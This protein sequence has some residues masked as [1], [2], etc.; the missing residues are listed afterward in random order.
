MQIANA[1]L[2]RL[3]ETARSPSIVDLDVEGIEYVVTYSLDDGSSLP[4]EEGK[5]RRYIKPRAFGEALVFV[6]PAIW[7]DATELHAQWSPTS[8]TT[9]LMKG[10]AQ[11]HEPGLSLSLAF[12]SL[13][14]LAR[15]LV[16]EMTKEAPGNGAV[17]DW[18]TKKATTEDRFSDV[19]ELLCG[20]TLKENRSLWSDF[21]L[22]K[23][24]RDTYMHSGI[25]RA[26]G[27]E[28]SEADV[29]KY[30]QVAVDITDFIWNSL[31]EQ[32]KWYRPELPVVQFS[33]S[34]DLSAIFSKFV[35]K[36]T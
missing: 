6:S 5:Y 27:I 12:L 23:G 29:P 1:V 26:N 35:P 8:W 24:I 31:P 4:D 21:K 15:H 17:W 19:L 36:P 22:L 25:P 18:I 20:R 7:K 14:I 33:G 16:A 34:A 9:V 2:G 30:L 32:L 10:M 11:Q 28:I 3:R 13:E